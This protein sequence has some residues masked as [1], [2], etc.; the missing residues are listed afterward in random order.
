MGERESCERLSSEYY[1]IHLVSPNA[2]NSIFGNRTNKPGMQNSLNDIQ[3]C[4]ILSTKTAA[5]CKCLHWLTSGNMK[6]NRTSSSEQLFANAEHVKHST[7][8]S[9]K[10]TEPPRGTHTRRCFPYPRHIKAICLFIWERALLNQKPHTRTRSAWLHFAQK[11]R[12]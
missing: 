2:T 1:N 12:P 11:Q 4:E 8:H 5:K 9:H 6:W 10:K 3:Q 7:Y